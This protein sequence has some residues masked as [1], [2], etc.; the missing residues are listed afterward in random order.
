MGKLK[1][2]DI[3]ELYCLSDVMPGCF[4]HLSEKEFRHDEEHKYVKEEPA[5]TFLGLMAGETYWCYVQ[6]DAEQEKRDQ[7]NMRKVWAGVT[8]AKATEGEH[9]SCKDG[10]PCTDS[11]ICNDWPNHFANALK[12]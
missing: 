5:G 9:C 11:S 10:A 7:E 1:A 6:Q 12:A 2:T 3:D 8:Q 4:I